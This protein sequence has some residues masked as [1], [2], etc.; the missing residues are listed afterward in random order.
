MAVYKGREVQILGR[1]DGA[2]TSPMYRVL[3]PYGQE[4]QVSLS[5]IQVTEEEKKQILTENQE[6]LY[7]NVIKDKDL[8]DLRDSQDPEKI[9]AK[10]DKENKNK[11]VP[12]SSV[13]V[14]ADEVARKAGK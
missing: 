14:N 10:E 9:K 12:V 1:A 5:Q 8:Q 7:V 4:E 13:K 11:D 6:T 2:D 3:D